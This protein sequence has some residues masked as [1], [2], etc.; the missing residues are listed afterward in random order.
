MSPVNSK[1]SCSFASSVAIDERVES[2]NQLFD[3][4]QLQDLMKEYEIHKRKFRQVFAAILDELRKS[5][6]TFTKVLENNVF[7][8]Y[9]PVEHMDLMI[10]EDRVHANNYEL[11]QDFMKDINL[12]CANV[13]Q[14]SNARSTNHRDTIAKVP[15][16]W[17]SYF[18]G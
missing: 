18:L 16:L 12:I 4:D 8:D 10:M 15:F 14:G 13:L 5:Y 3:A 9:Q 2:I 6:R 1:P 17:V 7:P 11:P